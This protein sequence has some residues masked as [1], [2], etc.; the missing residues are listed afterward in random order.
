LG[1]GFDGAGLAVFE[2][3]AESRARKIKTTAAGIVAARQWRRTPG[4]TASMT[5]ATTVV[6]DCT[7]SVILMAIFLL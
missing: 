4:G 2:S 7:K 1:S 6:S 3:Q 5:S